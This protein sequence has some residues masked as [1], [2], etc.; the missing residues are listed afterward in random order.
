[1]TVTIVRVIVEARCGRLNDPL[2]CTERTSIEEDQIVMR[3]VTGRSMSLADIRRLR[4]PAVGPL[5]PR[6]RQ[7]V[8][9][10]QWTNM[11]VN[12]IESTE[13]QRNRFGC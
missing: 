1:M 12:D 4:L 5:V 3:C 9:W 7:D 2:L 10:A 6:S 11:N 8:G 13:H